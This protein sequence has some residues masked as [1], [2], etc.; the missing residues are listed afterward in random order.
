MW[1]LVLKLIGGPDKVIALLVNKVIGPALAKSGSGWKTAAGAFIYVLG[2]VA[3]ARP[4]YP[5]LAKVAELMAPYAATIQDT[6]LIAILIG[7]A[8]KLVSFIPKPK[9]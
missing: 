5:I 8:S 1:N 6:G 4:N 9:A 2:Y 3:A 7:L